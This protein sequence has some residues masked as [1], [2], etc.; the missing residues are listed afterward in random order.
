MMNSGPSTK[1]SPALLSRDTP[2]DARSRE[3]CARDE[4]EDGPEAECRER[5][6]EVQARDGRFKAE[7]ERRRSLD[8]PHALAEVRVEVS[9]TV[10][11]EYVTCTRDDMV[12]DRR[13]LRL[14][15]GVQSKVHAPAAQRGID[16]LRADV[17]LD[18]FEAVA[19]PPGRGRWKPSLD[20]T[21]AA[22]V[23]NV[24]DAPRQRL[25]H[26]VLEAGAEDRF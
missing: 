3:L 13:P 17:D 16:H 25:E 1:P 12:H 11:I 14:S 22:L 15:F 9:E 7:R 23:R 24:V 6:Y 8:P 2:R 5:P 19:D 26:P 10:D 20:E 21:Q 4:A 18:T